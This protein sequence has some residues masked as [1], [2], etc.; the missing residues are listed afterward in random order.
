LDF[1]YLILSLAFFGFSSL[2]LGLL[3]DVLAELGG[4]FWDILFT[5]IEALGALEVLLEENGI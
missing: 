1:K 4:D 2:L 5:R 3:F